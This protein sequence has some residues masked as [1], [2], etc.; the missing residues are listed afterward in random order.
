MKNRAFMV[1]LFLLFFIIIY[2][3]PHLLEA[4]RL[5]AQA[6]MDFPE[7]PRVSAYETY[8]KHKA[9]K[10]VLLHAGGNSYKNQHIMGSINAPGHLIKEGKFKLPKLPKKGIEIFIYCY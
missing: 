7:V 6:G 5:K 8:L 10:G 2:L 4:K 3:H 1:I 9:G